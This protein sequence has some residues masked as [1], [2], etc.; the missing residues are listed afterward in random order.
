MQSWRNN[1]SFFL[2]NRQLIWRPFVSKECCVSLIGQFVFSLFRFLSWHRRSYKNIFIGHTHLFIASITF[3][4]D[5]SLSLLHHL[6]KLQTAHWSHSYEINMS[7][8]CNH[9]FLSLIRSHY[10]TLLT[11][12]H[13]I[14][15]LNHALLCIPQR[16]ILNPRLPPI[17]MIIW[18]KVRVIN[19]NYIHE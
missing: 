18:Y 10:H 17:P 5:L 2:L 3:I 9:P 6:R 14:C 11:Y 7:I 15:K 12:I 8:T 16:R 19:L 1:V 13:T 4:I